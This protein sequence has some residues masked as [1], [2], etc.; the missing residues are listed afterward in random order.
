M[1][2]RASPIV[3]LA[4]LLGVGLTSA[5]GFWQLDRAA[6]KERLRD[7]IEAG[8]RRAPLPLSGRL[9]GPEA[10]AV[11]LSRVLARGEFQADLTVL[12]DN[13]T[14]AGVPGYEIVTP[15]KLSGSNRFILIK[16]GWVRAGLR[17]EQLPAVPVPEGVVTVTGLA[18]APSSRF[19][20]LGNTAPVGRVWENLTVARFAQRFGI[21]L[22]PLIL[23]QESDAPDGLQRVWPRADLGIDRHH[24]YAFQWFALAVLIIVVFLVL[25]VRRK[26]HPSGQSA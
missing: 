9:Q 26:S 6:Q 11:E 1:P 18:L 12:L 13:R 15:L 22:L 20:E 16:R 17:R 3:A 25:H 21:D 19:L 8:A 10:R 2:L 5:L 4:A 7:R 23:Q 14:R 24:A